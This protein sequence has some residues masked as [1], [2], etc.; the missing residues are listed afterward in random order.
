MRNAARRSAQA[1]HCRAA[2]CLRIWKR[3]GSEMTREMARSSCFDK[4]ELVLDFVRLATA[5]SSYT[6]RMHSTGALSDLRSVASDH[7]SAE[8]GVLFRILWRTGMVW[9]DA[10]ALGSET[11]CHSNLERLKVTH[12]AVKPPFSVRAFKICPAES[13]AQLSHA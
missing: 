3:R 2:M 10:A 12:L 9:A 7:S 6:T 13:R 4:T 5:L 8:L 11:E 1:V